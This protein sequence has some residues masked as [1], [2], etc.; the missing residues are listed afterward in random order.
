[1]T[2]HS[3]QRYCAH[4]IALF[5]SRQLAALARKRQCRRAVLA[6]LDRITLNK[7]RVV[8]SHVDPGFIHACEAAQ[9]NGA[10]WVHT[11]HTMYFP[12]DWGGKLVSWQEEINSCLIETAA[13]ANVRISISQ[14]LHDHLADKYGISTIIVP[15]GVD[16]EMCESTTAGV[17]RRE[18]G[19]GD[20][21]LFVGSLA[22]V[23]NPSLFIDVA[24]SVPDQLFVMV[25]EDL[26]GSKVEAYHGRP[27]PPNLR[28][29]GPLSHVDALHCI[30]DAAALVVTSHSEGLPT[31]VMEAMAMSKA[32]IAPNS[33][34]CGDLIRH[35]VNGLVYEPGSL[36]G[37]H[38]IVT[39]THDNVR[40][41]ASARQ[42]VERYYAWKTVGRQLDEI[43]FSLINA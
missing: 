30:R 27:L 33:F 10:S 8:H 19:V 43:Y 3:L 14:W 40:M 38:K 42:D 15:N 34:G 7:Y 9:R 24:A 4:E 31:V 17:F 39:G 28:L 32:V 22:E 2:R 18:Y 41:G 29:L 26:H 5:P 6:A 16:T 1:M 13:K 20:F 36:Q 23:K 35:G 25:G 37:L 21:F 12:E 11:Y